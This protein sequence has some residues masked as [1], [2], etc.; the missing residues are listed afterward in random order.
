[1]KLPALTRRT[2]G[3]ARPEGRRS[4]EATSAGHTPRSTRRPA[5]RVAMLTE[6]TYPYVDG[7]VSIWCHILCQQLVGHLPRS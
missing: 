7:G 1:M 2:Q 6:G 5:L 3:S 4:G